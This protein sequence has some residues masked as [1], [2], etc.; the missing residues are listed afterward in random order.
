MIRGSLKV[1]EI[2][3]MRD[4]KDRSV[5]VFMSDF[6]KWVRFPKSEVDFGHRR[7]L[8]PEWLARK[9]LKNEK[10]VPELS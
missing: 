6:D 10:S 1:F 7:I 9:M 5:E 8:V 3:D 4:P 2:S